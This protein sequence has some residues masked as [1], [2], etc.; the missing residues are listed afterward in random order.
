MCEA[1]IFRQPSREDKAAILAFR[2]AFLSYYADPTIHGSSGLERFS[3]DGFEGWLDYVYAPVGTNLFGYAKIESDNFLIDKQGVV[4]GMLSVRYA[5]TPS[6]LAV[7]GHIGYSTHPD[8]QGQGVASSA[9]AY[10]IKLLKA[11]GVDRVLVTCDDENV[12]SA[13]VIEK[14]GGVLENVL[15]TTGGRYRRYWIAV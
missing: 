1:L 6:L 13:C 2:R 15:A 3:E 4:V 14:N 9:L 10:G 12:G 11:R 8:Y 5:L 7:G